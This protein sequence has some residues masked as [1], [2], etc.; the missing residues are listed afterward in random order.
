MICCPFEEIASAIHMRSH[1]T[2]FMS[3]EKFCFFSLLGQWYSLSSSVFFF[4][5]IILFVNIYKLY[6]Y[7]N[8][9]NKISDNN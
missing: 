5:K 2:S 1:S 8:V 6:L 3:K 7:D 9:N 4:K